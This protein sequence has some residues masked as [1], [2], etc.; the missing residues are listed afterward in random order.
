M[1]KQS[2][3][4]VS[5]LCLRAVGQRKLTQPFLHSHGSYLSNLQFAPSG[6]D[7]VTQVGAIAS[8]RGE[9]A[10]AVIKVRV[11]LKSNEVSSQLRD[12][13]ANCLHL[14]RIVDLNTH[15]NNL[16]LRI[17]LRWVVT[18]S[19]HRYLAVDTFSKSI[20]LAPAINPNIYV[21]TSFDCQRA[22]LI[23][24]PFQLS[25]FPRNGWRH[26][27]NLALIAAS[28]SDFLNFQRLRVRFG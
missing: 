3:H 8:F 18:E 27:R 6:N 10:M 25:S 22:M 21:G 2:T 19:A 20:S 12:C 16:S 23:A 28:R 13:H 15:G 1:T 4:V 17:T 7:P 5:D 9:C 11:K 26:E 24:L 14:R